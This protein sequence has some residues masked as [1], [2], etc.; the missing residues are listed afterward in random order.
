MNS[1]SRFNQNL[2]S[3][4]QSP[5]NTERDG[6]YLRSSYNNLR[7]SS[8]PFSPTSNNFNN[9]T[10]ST[11]NPGSSSKAVLAALRALQD[12]IRR[13]ES[14]KLQALDE[15]KSLRLQIQNKEIEN[16]KIKNKEKLNLTKSISEI[17]YAYENAMSENK[18]LETRI[19]KL[20]DRNREIRIH[21]EELYEKIRNLEN[22]KHSLEFKLKDLESKYLH[23]EVQID[24]TQQREKG[25]LYTVY[26]NCCVRVYIISYVYISY[27][28]ILYSYSLYITLCMYHHTSTYILYYTPHLTPYI[29]YIHIYTNRGTIQV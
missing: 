21:S 17:K 26:V 20:E 5:T 25:M 16:E 6:D 22:E 4:F 27:M 14:E 18:E 24:R 3:R 15:T 9:T 11:T 8:T 7:T 1:Q 2:N 29:Y 19:N 12:K 23:L 28:R 10:N 13:L